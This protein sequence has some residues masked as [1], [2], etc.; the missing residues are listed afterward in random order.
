MEKRLLLVT[1]ALARR[2]GLDRSKLIALAIREILERE[3]AS[4]KHEP[5]ADEL[6]GSMNLPIRDTV[7]PHSRGRK[8]LFR[9]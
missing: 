9:A 3:A 6:V 2:K 5:A 8:N 7:M 4:K 1:D